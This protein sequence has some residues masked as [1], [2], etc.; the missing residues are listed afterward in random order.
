MGGTWL[1]SSHHINLLELVAVEKVLNHFTP[2][3]RGKH[4]M[5]GWDNTTVEVNLNR[6]E[7]V[8]SPALLTAAVS[9]LMWTDLSTFTLLF[10]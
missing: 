7:V 8:G 3:L 10:T 4:V 1:D 6:Q 2:Q 9:V 5:L